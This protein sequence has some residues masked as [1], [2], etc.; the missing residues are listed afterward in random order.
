[1]EQKALEQGI[2]QG[3]TLGLIL[4][5]LFVSPLGG[6]CQAQ[7]IKFAGYADNTQNYMSFRPL[8]ISLEPQ[9]TCINKL[10]L[11][12]ADVR[13]WDASKFPKVK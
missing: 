7:G 8:T 2:P 5:N 6:I 10:E 9:I 4:F 12:L 3:S 13:S 1:M 11:C